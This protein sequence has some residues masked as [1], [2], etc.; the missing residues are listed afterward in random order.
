MKAIGL[1]DT[2]GMLLVFPNSWPHVYAYTNQ[3]QL[4]SDTITNPETGD[5]FVK[6]YTWQGAHIVAE[7]GWTHE[8]R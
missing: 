1:Y 4:M 8:S 2:T 7:S 6:T 5:S 3:D